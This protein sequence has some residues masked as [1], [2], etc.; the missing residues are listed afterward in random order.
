MNNSIL[1]EIATVLTALSVPHETGVYAAPEP[2]IYAVIVPLVDT[3]EVEADDIPNA[4]TQEARIALYS[5]SN[6]RSTA[7]NIIKALLRAGL[8]VT[9]RQYIEYES[10]TGYHHFNIDVAQAYDYNTNE[11]E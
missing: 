4:E 10:D 11:E 1:S 7:N 9:A 3:F 8:T 5:K 6:Y 2:D